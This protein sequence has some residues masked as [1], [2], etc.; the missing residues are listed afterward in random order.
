MSATKRS[1][2]SISI[3]ESSQVGISHDGVQ[4][5]CCELLMDICMSVQTHKHACALAP[6][7][8]TSM[9]PDCLAFASL[10]P[11][12]YT[13][14]Q[15]VAEFLQRCMCKCTSHPQSCPHTNPASY[16]MKLDLNTIVISSTSHNIQESAVLV[17]LPC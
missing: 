8:I 4:G 6:T 5:V 3:I 12:L 14:N 2:M 16:K 17:R 7:K 1:K 10:D 13:P 9:Y 15:H 11:V